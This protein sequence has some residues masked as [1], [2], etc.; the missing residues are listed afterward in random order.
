MPLS[1]LLALGLLPGI[2]AA[3]PLPVRTPQFTLLPLG[4][5]GGGFEENMSCF[6]LKPYGSK[7]FRTLIDGGSL[8][9]GMARFEERRRGRPISSQERFD[10]LQ[11]LFFELEDV[12]ITHSH[13]D[14]LGGFV[15]QS[16]FAFGRK[17]PVRL[18]AN[19]P[20]MKALSD[21]ALSPPLWG[22]FKGSGKF[23]FLSHPPKSRYETPDFPVEILPL[24]HT[25]P[26]SAFVF[27]SSEGDAY[28]HLGDTGPTRKTFPR[29]RDLMAKGKLRG[30]ALECSFENSKEELALLT[31]H[32]TP[33][34]LAQHLFD[35][36]HPDRE[37]STPDH[38]STGR[39]LG[40][41]KVL[42][43]HIKPE[44]ERKIRVQIQ[45]LRQAG[46]PLLILEQGL[47]LDL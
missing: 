17:K 46:L 36:T 26:G 4:T 37:G 33:K 43:H 27:Y 19:P 5:Y 40:S 22:D 25:V 15:I 9:S 35:L 44:D 30:L 23:E 47:S 14:H 2:A 3:V 18:H 6:A 11:R 39:R 20:T 13:L 10:L 29:A 12:H 21:V 31:G 24:D 45:A 42:V 7:T 32:L 38:A 28:M 8:S 41:M 34:L 1:S 16:P